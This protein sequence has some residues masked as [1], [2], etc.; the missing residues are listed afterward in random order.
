[1]LCRNV[2]LQI[3]I[4]GYMQLCIYTNRA[5]LN[6]NRPNQVSNGIWAV[7]S[8]KIFYTKFRPSL[9]EKREIFFKYSFLKKTL[10][11]SFLIIV[12]YTFL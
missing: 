2:Y 7:E 4:F 3:S 6:L 11:G 5:K 9:K 12:F 8:K 10:I 1:M